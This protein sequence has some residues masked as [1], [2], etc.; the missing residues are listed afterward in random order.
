MRAVVSF[1]VS[2]RLPDALAPLHELAY[3]LRWSWDDHSQELFR[4]MDGEAWEASGHDPVRMLGL[5]PYERL[6]EL[7]AE[8]TFMAFLTD[9]HN[10]LR[11]YLQGSGWFQTRTDSPLRSVGYFSPEFGITEALPQYSGGLGV[12]AGDHLK[13]ASALNV[14][15]TGVGLLYR[16]AYFHQDL[17]ADG[18]QLERYPTLDPHTMPLELVKGA[19][20]ELDLAGVALHAQVWRA[21]VGRVSLYLLD[22]DVD[23][24]E[25][26]CRQ[27]TDRLY[28]GDN[29]HR[30]RQEILLGRCPSSST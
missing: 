3:N 20:L 2:A 28:G 1:V 8:P 21:Q 27:V 4:W 29:E 13:A 24:N 26:A 18:W 9:V 25:E 22:A 19:A 23:A 10:E 12:L 5:V 11:R 6:E 17:D 7:A 30:L 14:P 16:H 15:I